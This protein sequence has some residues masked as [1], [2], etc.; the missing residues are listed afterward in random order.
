MKYERPNP[1][2]VMQ[3]LILNWRI[4]EYAEIY[5]LTDALG[6]GKIERAKILKEF[7]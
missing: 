3:L 7:Q 1:E 2:L 6:W 4:V 5:G